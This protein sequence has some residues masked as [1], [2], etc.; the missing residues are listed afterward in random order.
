[1]ETSMTP[2]QSQDKITHVKS[3]GSTSFRML[4]VSLAPGHA[5]LVEPG[6]MASQDTRLKVD[7]QVNG[8]LWE[9]F[10]MRFLGQESFFINFFINPSSSQH[11]EFYVSQGT[12]G[13]ILSRELAGNEAFFVQ[14]G[15]LLARTPLV[16]TRVVWA[17]FASW[18]GGEGLFRLEISGK[19]KVW[20]GVYGGVVEREVDGDFLVDSGHLLSYPKDMK[21]S[22]KLAGGL[23]SSLFSGE[24][25]L[26]KLTGKGKIQLQTRSIKG[27]AQWLNPRFWG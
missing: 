10:L 14:P 27:L 17:G 19:G 26:L 5:L 2:L 7:T 15:A 23:F 16:Q 11:L 8:S 25:L 6:A 1:M 4:Q 21:L 20:Y 9:A 24:G 13:E 12:P 3:I 18:L 22:L